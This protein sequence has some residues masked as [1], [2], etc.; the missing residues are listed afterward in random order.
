MYKAQ[1][2]RTW[3]LLLRNARRHKWV[4]LCQGG[5]HLTQISIFNAKPL[6]ATQSFALHLLNSQMFHT[7][8]HDITCAAYLHAGT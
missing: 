6:S 5:R 1:M 7:I 3:S 4:L 8:W 2:V